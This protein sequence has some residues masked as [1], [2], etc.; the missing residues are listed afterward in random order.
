MTR[1]NPDPEAEDRFDCLETDVYCGSATNTN[2][3]Y[4]MQLPPQRQDSLNLYEIVP[5]SAVP[6]CHQNFPSCVCPSLVS[7]SMFAL[8]SGCPNLSPSWRLPDVIDVLVE[9]VCNTDG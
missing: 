4:K 1:D 5:Q 2:N 7:R 8:V 6:R 9:P 3:C